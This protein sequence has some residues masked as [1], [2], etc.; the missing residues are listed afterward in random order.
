MQWNPTQLYNVHGWET[1]NSFTVFE[2]PKLSV[3]DQQSLN[4]QGWFLNWLLGPTRVLEAVYKTI[5]VL[6][7]KLYAFVCVGK[8][9]LNVVWGSRA[10]VCQPAR[11][12]L[13]S[14]AVLC[15]VLASALAV[16]L[17]YL[18]CP[19]LAIQNSAPVYFALP[20][21]CP[22]L[23]SPGNWKL[24]PAVL[25]FPSLPCTM[26]LCSWSSRRNYIF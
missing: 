12:R 11:G 16:L 24:C 23:P 20:C 6:C 15:P 21:P 8:P 25:G 26:Q 18:P 3:R 17:L 14:A 2:N 7:F 10:A 1:K 5:C 9:S 19:P 22:N 13:S 4:C